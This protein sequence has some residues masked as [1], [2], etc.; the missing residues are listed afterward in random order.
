MKA[1]AQF[2]KLYNGDSRLEVVPDAIVNKYSRRVQ[3]NNENYQRQYKL[4]I[5]LWIVNLVFEWKKWDK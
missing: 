5:N 1:N 3:V 4:I 2:K